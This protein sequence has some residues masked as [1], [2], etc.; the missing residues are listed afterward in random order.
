MKLLV[1]CDQV[2][3][4]LTRGPFP[5]GSPDDD[6]V[7]RHLDACHECRQLAEALRPAV[8]LMHES[9]PAAESADLPSYGAA[10]D[11]QG[12][13]QRADGALAARIR[14]M[15]DRQEPEPRRIATEEKWV[16][17]A[18]YVAGGVLALS[19]LTLAGGILWRGNDNAERASLV[20]VPKVWNAAHQPSA[21]GLLRLASLKLPAGCMPG[22]PS[23]VSAAS[24]LPHDLSI[25]A[26]HVCCTRCHAA[27]KDGAVLT[28]RVIAALQESCA[29]C[30]AARS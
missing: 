2:F 22:M 24:T 11:D 17:A 12:L 7:Q 14:Q 8:A 4:C 15:M 21:D 19:L 18:R 26:A 5:S 25:G 6:G 23:P 9:L 3:D 1:T 29:A 10:D 27:G 30:H 13:W 20:G 28:H 16:Q